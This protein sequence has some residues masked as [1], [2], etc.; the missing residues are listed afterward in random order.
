MRIGELAN[1]SGTPASTIRFYEQKGL[2]PKAS[3]TQ[4]GYRQYDEAALDRLQLIKF[5]QS[6]GFSLDELPTMLNNEQGWDH[7]EV[8]ERL[9]EKYKEVDVL[10]QQL[11]LKK[12]QISELM[13]TLKATWDSGACMDKRELARILSNTDL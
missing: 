10:L 9:E 4:T 7:D 5:G 12:R 8:M 1:K 13:E 3:R 6:L 2:M 11:L